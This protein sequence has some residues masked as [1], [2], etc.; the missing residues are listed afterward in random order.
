MTEFGKWGRRICGALCGGLMGLAAGLMPLAA[1]DLRLPLQQG[2]PDLALFALS[3]SETQISQLGQFLLARQGFRHQPGGPALQTLSRGRL[4]VPTL[5]H[6][7]NINDGIPADRITLGG[8]AFIVT[9]ESRAKEALLIGVQYSGWQ[10]W[11]YAPGARLRLSQSLSAELEPTHGYHHAGA[12][13]RLCAEHPVAAWTWTDACLAASAQYDGRDTQG[14]FT[15]TLGARHLF[16]SGAGS[17]QIGFSLGTTAT[18]GYRKEV[19][20]LSH[21]VLT[22]H[23]GMWSLGY[24]WGE[25]IQGENTMRRRLSL[26]WTGEVAGRLVTL[27]LSETHFGG[28]A[29]FGMA[30]DERRTR[31]GVTLPV[32]PLDIGSWIETRDASIDAWRGTDMG[33]SVSF[34]MNLL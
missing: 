16:Q 13:L 4:L 22:D 30:R 7:P 28:G 24:A 18:E 15:A 20:Q 25:E 8:L 27:S 9:P 23:A 6:D 5:R 10:S 3:R 19:V 26:D 32:G 34:R 2:Q 31:A 21:Q 33:L 1:Q 17:H 14:A 12:G 11:S 29:L